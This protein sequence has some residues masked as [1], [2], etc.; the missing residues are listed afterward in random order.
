[1]AIS[2]IAEIGSGGRVVGPETLLAVGRITTGGGLHIAAGGI[3]IF[4]IA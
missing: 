3:T 4:G 1:M 2:V